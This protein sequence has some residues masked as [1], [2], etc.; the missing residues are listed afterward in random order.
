MPSPIGGGYYSPTGFPQ[1]P[2]EGDNNERVVRYGHGSHGGRGGGAGRGRG[3]MLSR[4]DYTDHP[5]GAGGQQVGGRTPTHERLEYPE[6]GQRSVFE[7]LAPRIPVKD[8]L[9]DQTVCRPMTPGR[10]YRG[11]DDDDL[12]D[13]PRGDD[14]TSSRSATDRTPRLPTSEKSQPAGGKVGGQVRY[15]CVLTGA[16]SFTHER[17]GPIIEVLEWAQNWQRRYTACPGN[18]PL[19]VVLERIGGETEAPGK[20]QESDPDGSSGS[21]P[22]SAQAP[23]V[24]FGDDGTTPR[25]CLKRTGVTLAQPAIDPDAAPPRE[26]QQG[27]D[28]RLTVY[29]N[30]VAQRLWREDEAERHGLREHCSRVVAWHANDPEG[31]RTLVC[32]D[33][34]QYLPEQA[35]VR[36]R[37]LTRAPDLGPLSS[38]LGDC[39]RCGLRPACR[40]MLS[41]ASPSPGGSPTPRGGLCDLCV[42]PV[43]VGHEKALCLHMELSDGDGTTPGTAC[44]VRRPEV[45]GET[46]EAAWSAQ[47]TPAAPPVTPGLQA[48]TE[49]GMYPPTPMRQGPSFGQAYAARLPTAGSAISEASH[50]LKLNEAVEKVVSKKIE[51]LE[52]KR[53]DAA[54]MSRFLRSLQ[55]LLNSNQQIR[56]AREGGMTEATILHIAVG[57]CITPDSAVARAVHVKWVDYSVFEAELG[58]LHQLWNFLTSATCMDQKVIQETERRFTEMELSEWAE[59]EKAIRQAR[60]K[61]DAACLRP[62]FQERFPF[63]SLPQRIVHAVKEP[64]RDLLKASLRTEQVEWESEDLRNLSAS[65]VTSVLAAVETQW[66]LVQTH[67][68]AQTAAVRARGERLYPGGGGKRF[69]DRFQRKPGSPLVVLEQ[70]ETDDAPTGEEPTADESCQALQAGGG[71]AAGRTAPGMTPPVRQP[72]VGQVG[73]GRQPNRRMV[74]DAR[75]RFTA[76]GPKPGEAGYAGCYNC[77]DKDHFARHCP[78]GLSAKLAALIEACQSPDDIAHQEGWS[79]VHQGLPPSVG[80]HLNSVETERFEVCCAAAVL[81]GSPEESDPDQAESA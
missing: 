18:D 43:R 46:G 47:K 20:E 81:Y 19:A 30:L 77:G 40:A 78:R 67:V 16:D 3:G 6:D 51:Q 70:Q 75:R 27:T 14:R 5:V 12:D 15:R 64:M 69:P 32:E 53:T 28:L 9:E 54:E 21:P 50:R 56:V 60:D 61:Y 39:W 36:S 76:R 10:S 79:V 62:G 29:G 25:S 80:E 2:R 52:G 4:C 65:E 66:R 13:L 35:W 26:E 33:R 59:P 7:R 38:T 22:D 17:E 68:D 72:P 71:P 58:T 1:T 57:V 49:G 11:D 42:S 63:H 41:G 31:W 74:D 73:P 44:Y 45:G 37:C 8:R 48:R 55:D 23:G 24:K 34:V